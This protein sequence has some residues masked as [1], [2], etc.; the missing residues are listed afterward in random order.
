M[1]TT[2]EPVSSTEFEE[3]EAAWDWGFDANLF[4]VSARFG[5]S[6]NHLCECEGISSVQMCSAGSHLMGHGA[7]Q[8]CV[9]LAHTPQLYCNQFDS[10]ICIRGM[11]SQM[12]L[13]S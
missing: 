6:T 10:R 7:Q 11:K 9:D 12:V 8:M 1:T 4:E 13:K 2:F 5:L 3:Q